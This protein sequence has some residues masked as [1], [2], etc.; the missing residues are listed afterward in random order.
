MSVI[1]DASVPMLSMPI[2]G[3]YEQELNARYLQKLGYGMFLDQPADGGRPLDR[4]IVAEF[5][6]KTPDMTRALE[7]YVPRDN[8]MLFGCI[9]ELL[10]DVD[11]DEPPP[12]RLG[13]RALGSW[14]GPDLPPHLLDAVENDEEVTARPGQVPSSRKGDDGASKG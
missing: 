7:S 11:I 12:Q 1:E 3:Q 5:L 14:E 10:R 8:T 4:E 2:G 9:D 13:T 6:G